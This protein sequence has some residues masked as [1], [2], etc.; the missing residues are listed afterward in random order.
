MIL[1]GLLTAITEV[2]AWK[3]R[4]L[5]YLQF[6]SPGFQGRDGN[7]KVSQERL[8][9]PLDFTKVFVVRL[10]PSLKIPFLHEIC[11]VPSTSEQVG[12]TIENC[13]P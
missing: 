5:K 8:Q 10:I 9:T 2:V 11:S 12:I 13:L 1:L 6:V 4:Q 7:I 3:I